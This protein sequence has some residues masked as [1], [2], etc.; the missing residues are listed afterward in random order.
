MLL[1]RIHSHRCSREESV[2]SYQN[3]QFVYTSTP[4]ST[5]RKVV[6]TTVLLNHC[7][8]RKFAETNEK[9]NPPKYGFILNSTLFF[10][11]FLRLECNCFA[12]CESLRHND[13]NQL[14]V[15]TR[16]LLLGPPSH[17]SRSSQSPD[18]SPLL[19]VASSH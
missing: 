11:P 8:S 7:N 3:D 19:Y 10:S 17:P 14:Y 18:L 2:S 4:K 5:Y 16:P 1:P 12:M 13:V 9:L 15:Q 6:F